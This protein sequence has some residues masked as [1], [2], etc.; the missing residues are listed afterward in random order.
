MIKPAETRTHRTSAL[1]L[2][3]EARSCE[4]KWQ[5]LRGFVKS[6]K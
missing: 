5:L 4:G 6:Q 3:F 2:L 1:V